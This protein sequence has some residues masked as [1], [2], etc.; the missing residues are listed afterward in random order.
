MGFRGLGIG[1]V[2]GLGTLAVLGPSRR[3]DAV[4]VRNVQGVNV[5]DNET[6]D[7]DTTVGRIVS[8]SNVSGF[9]VSISIGTSNSPGTAAGGL[10][11]LSSLTI[12]N[13]HAQAATLNIDL[14]DANFALPGD[15]GD[16][17]DLLSSV[18]GTFTFAQPTDHISF[19]SF[20]DPTGAQPVSLAA[21]ST[22]AI[23]A[24]AAAP[25]FSGSAATVFPHGAG[26]YSLQSHASITLSPGAQLNLSGT[27]QAA[28]AVPEP[29][30]LS[31]AALG[32]AG[33]L[34]RRRRRTRA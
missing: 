9:G 19:Q 34:A 14:S 33:L 27:T 29:A 18:G 4:L 3:A 31:L 32:A 8:N 12:E 25:S 30:T 10:L 24:T 15:S 11:Q 20:A 17:L 5:V 13:N 1:L 22:A 6:G 16:V 21:A 26:L 2:C 28:A 23:N 7:S